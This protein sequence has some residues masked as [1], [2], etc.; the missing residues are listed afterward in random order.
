MTTADQTRNKS[1]INL[2]DPPKDKPVELKPLPLHSREWARHVQPIALSLL[3]LIALVIL[4][5]FLIILTSDQEKAR[6]ALDWSKTVLPPVV[7][8]GGALV[9]YYFRYARHPAGRSIRGATGGTVI[10]LTPWITDSPVS[11]AG[12]VSLSGRR[13]ADIPTG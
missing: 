13:L 5:P 8:F 12:P 11:F 10:H 1:A 7:G 6:N 2:K 4:L 9:G 3:G